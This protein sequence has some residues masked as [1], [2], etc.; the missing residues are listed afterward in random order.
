MRAIVSILATLGLATTAV[1]AE[2]EPDLDDPKVKAKIV[3]K[4]QAMNSLE[5]GFRVRIPR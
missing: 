4:A 1:A 3:A 2:K 5:G